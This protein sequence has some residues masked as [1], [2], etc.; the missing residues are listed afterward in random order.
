MTEGFLARLEAR[1]GGWALPNLTFYMM[2]GQILIFGLDLAWQSGLLEKSPLAV[3]GLQ[4]AKVVNFEVWRLVTF[5]FQTPGYSFHMLLLIFVWGI[6]YYTGST[7]EAAWGDFRYTVFILIYI[8]ATGLSSLALYAIFPEPDRSN[9]FIS[10]NHLFTTIFLAFAYLNPNVEFRLFFILPVK[11]KWLALFSLAVIGIAFIF[12]GIYAQITLS[13]AFINLI[14]F[15]GR[16][17]LF[18]ISQR[19]RRQSFQREVAQS[20]AGSFHTCKVCGATDLSHPDRA[21]TYEDGEGYCE[22]CVD[23]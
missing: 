7:L 5:I 14:L 13:A 9:L 10:N 3:I 23:R 20:Q 16:D 2:V 4:P 15:L 1:F 21:F 8:A 18:R 11:V 6:F 22:Q 12:G 19:R 17:C